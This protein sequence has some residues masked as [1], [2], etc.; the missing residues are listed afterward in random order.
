MDCAQVD[1]KLG[2]C[3]KTRA[4]GDAVIHEEHCLNTRIVRLPQ[5]H[6]NRKQSMAP[7]LMSGE[8]LYR[9]AFEKGG[10]GTIYHAVD[11]EASP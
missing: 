8:R 3:P 5:V 9:L 11:E 6:D 4:N 7:Y 10:P 1:L 2:R